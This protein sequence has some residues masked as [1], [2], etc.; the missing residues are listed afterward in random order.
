MVLLEQP[1]GWNDLDS[2]LAIRQAIGI[3]IAADECLHP[4]DDTRKVIAQSAADSTDVKIMKAGVLEE[5][6]IASLP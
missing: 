2:L 5:A 1:V 4:L 3:P 6:E